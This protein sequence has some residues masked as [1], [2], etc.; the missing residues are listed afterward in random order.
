MT[1]D[2]LASLH[3]RLFHV[4]APGAWAS[5]ERQGLLSTAA[6]LRLFDVDP[7]E[8]DRLVGQRRPQ[9]VALNHPEHGMA[10]LCDNRPL[11]E[12]KLARCLD[13]GLAPADWFRMLADRVFFWA[14]EADL[15]SLLGARGNRGRPR[16]VLVF[17]TRTLVAAH[18][19]VVEISPINSGATIHV[20][21]RRGLAT[22]TPL[23][24]VRY[25]E[26]RRV[27]GQR[28]RIREVV[29]RGAV[30]DAARHLIERRELGGG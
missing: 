22:F 13:D 6:L 2:E 17:D 20:P 5:M 3:P 30:R 14:A 1:T 10:V 23:A 19:D 28:D 7:A 9:E 11:S 4:T 15:A 8:V 16:D 21:A 24:S 12:K 25:R 29:V 18:L 26:W 27:R